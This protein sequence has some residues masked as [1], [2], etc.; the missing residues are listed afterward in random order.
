M[1]LFYKDPQINPFNEWLKA[2]GIY[3]ALGVAGLLLIIVAV[4]FILSKIKKD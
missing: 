3:V 4:I 1:F 2:N